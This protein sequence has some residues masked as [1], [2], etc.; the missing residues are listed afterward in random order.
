MKKVDYRD[1]KRRKQE[2]FLKLI[3]A[4]NRFEGRVPGRRPRDPEKEKV[5]LDLDK[6]RRTRYIETGKMEI[7]GSRRI[8]WRIDFKKG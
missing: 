3:D 6:A 7:L 1:W 5:L 4:E 8:K 2:I